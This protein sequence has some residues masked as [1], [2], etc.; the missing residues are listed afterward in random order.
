MFIGVRIYVSLCDCLIVISANVCVICDS[1]WC[2][3]V[4]VS[5]LSLCVGVP[6]RE[7][8]G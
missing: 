2:V 5:Y 8:M 6:V 7:C 4:L 1:E 3:W